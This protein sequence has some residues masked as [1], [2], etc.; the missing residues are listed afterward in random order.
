MKLDKYTSDRVFEGKRV[1][2]DEQAE[3]HRKRLK[4]ALDKRK[5]DMTRIRD[6]P[7][8]WSGD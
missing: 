1:L 8:V 7:E 2:T 5:N 6:F 4:R 3:R